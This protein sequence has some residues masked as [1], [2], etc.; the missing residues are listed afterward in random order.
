MVW[1]AHIGNGK[2]IIIFFKCFL[3]SDYEYTCIRTA[4]KVY[5]WLMKNSYD[6]TRSCHVTIKASS[7]L[8]LAEFTGTFLSDYFYSTICL[9]MPHTTINGPITSLNPPF[10]ERLQPAFEPL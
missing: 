8:Q 7:K 10:F 1:V 9:G 5:F 6:I 3:V 2:T 4:C